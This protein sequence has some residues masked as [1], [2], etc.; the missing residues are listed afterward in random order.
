MPYLIRKALEGDYDYLADNMRSSDRKEIFISHGYGVK[1]AMQDIRKYPANC[2]VIDG[3]PAILFGCAEYENYGVPWLLATNDIHKIPITFVRQSIGIV[4][5]WLDIYGYLTNFVHSENT[6]SVR[7]LI[8]LGFKN[9][10]DMPIGKHIFY[11]MALG[12][13]PCA[14][15][16]A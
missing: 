9:E 14:I 15:Q 10:G 5:D 3:E 8:E 12:V 4:Q 6:L 11:K 2:C 7:W 1:R 13:R 16:Q